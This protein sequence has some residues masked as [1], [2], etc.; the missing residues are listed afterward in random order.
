MKDKDK[1][2]IEQKVI[3]LKETIDQASEEIKKLQ[4]SLK[5]SEK[6]ERW[7]AVKGSFYHFVTSSGDIAKAAEYD[8]WTDR[9]RW[10]CGNYFRTEEEARTSFIYMVFNYYMDFGIDVPQ[11][12]G[13]Y[14]EDLEFYYTG[15]SRWIHSDYVNASYLYRWK[16]SS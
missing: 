6:S 2:E 11:V 5:E 10:K 12:D 13:K 9:G 4:E 8:D 16:K 1:E 7:R 14:P 3:G 15:E